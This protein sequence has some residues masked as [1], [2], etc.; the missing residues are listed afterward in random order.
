MREVVLVLAFVGA[1]LLGYKLISEVPSLIH[2]PLMS[3]MNALSGITVVGA[4]TA[5]GLALATGSKLAGFVAIVLAIINVV[6][7][8][9]VTHRMLRMFKSERRRNS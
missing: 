9:L 6:G 2:T 5:T 1:A 7:G 4:L 8:F 3:G